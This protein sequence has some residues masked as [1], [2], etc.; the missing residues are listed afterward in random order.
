MTVTGSPP[1]RRPAV[2][3][4]A[5]SPLSEPG[6][7]FVS[8]H[9]LTAVREEVTRADTKASVLLSGSVALP[10]LAASAA[11]ERLGSGPLGVAGAVLWLAG[12]V[13]LAVVVLPR[14]KPDSGEG[15]AD[16][17]SGGPRTAAA[18]SGPSVVVL[19]R[20]AGTDEVAAA[21][22]A[23]GRDPGRWL[24]E[25]SCALGTILA[26]KYRWM[27]WAVGCLVAG[28]AAVAVTAVG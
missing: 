14:T 9:L 18:A 27:R 13:M 24:L 1:H 15:G 25:Q 5:V 26:I 21:V 19:H 2:P 7:R 10:A 28:G 11:H 23:A 16:R 3:G 17:G 12:I 20:G 8:E 22:L 6:C 4:I